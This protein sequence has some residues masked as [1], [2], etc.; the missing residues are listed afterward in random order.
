M[1]RYTPSSSSFGT[2]EGQVSYAQSI[3]AAAAA[4]DGLICAGKLFLHSHC[5]TSILFQ[6][7]YV[8]SIKTH[9][10]PTLLK[11]GITDFYQ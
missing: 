4:I 9:T 10:G 5:G 6:G 3:R 7:G 8:H 11:T 2:S 1:L